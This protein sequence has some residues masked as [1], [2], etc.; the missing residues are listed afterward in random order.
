MNEFCE[1]KGIKREYSVAR[2]PQ[3]N[4]VAKRRNRTLIEV[5][6]TM[7]ADSKLPTTFWD[8]AVNT[9]CYVQTRVLMV[10]PHFMTPYE[11]FKGRSAA[12]SFM[13]PFGCHVTILNTLDQLGKFDGKSNE[14]IFIGY[15]TISKAFRV[16]NIRTRKV[17]ENLHITFLENK[18]MI[19]GTNSNDFA[20]KRASFDVEDAGIFNDA[21]FDRDKG[22]EDDYNNLEIVFSVSPI[23]FTRIHKHHAKEQIIGETKIHVD[24]ESTICMVKNPVYH[25]KTKHIKIRN[26][27]IRDSYVK[28]LIEMVKIHTDYNVADLLTKAFDVTRFQFLNASIRLSEGFSKN[29]IK[30]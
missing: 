1:E 10:K 11:M 15:S 9:A 5:A 24:N 14:G 8:K 27:F 22:V 3:Q 17:E 4:K 2:T 23:P 6:R 25:S 18:H 19:A 30:L 12:L 21:Y 13:R 26:H 28:R 7:L 29:A 20:G 16:Y